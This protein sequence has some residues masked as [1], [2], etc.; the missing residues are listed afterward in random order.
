[1]A[2]LGKSENRVYVLASTPTRG[3]ALHLTSGRQADAPSAA[4]ANYLNLPR[5][6]LQARALPVL[7]WRPPV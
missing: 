3:R 7:I 4:Q 6:G 2:K 1:M 5:F